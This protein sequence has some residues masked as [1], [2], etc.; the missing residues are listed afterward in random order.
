MC[1]HL[2]QVSEMK[3]N[4][5][6]ASPGLGDTAASPFVFKNY[7][8]TVKLNS[9]VVS[10]GASVV[11]YLV[12]FDLSLDPGRTNGVY[13]VTMDIQGT[14]PDGAPVQ[15]TFTSYVTI[16]DGKKPISTQEPVVEKPTSEPKLIISAYSVNPSPV[17][18]GKEFTAT[19]SFKNT[20]STKA[21]QNATVTVACESTNISLQNAS[22]TFFIKNLG[23]GKTTDINFK[24]KTDLDTPA[25]PIKITFAMSYDNAQA[26]AL[27]ST[28][29]ISV[30]VKQP[31]RVQMKVPQIEENV[32]AGDTLPL[33]FQVM[34][35][36]RSKIYNVRFELNAPGLIP[37]GAAFAGNMDA[38]T[39]SR[40]EMDLFI[41][42]K[43]MSKD[44][45]GKDKYG[46]STGMFTLIYED[47]TGKEYK[48]TEEF[49]TIIK[50]PVISNST[51]TPEKEVK[52]AGQWWVSIVI[53][54][55]VIAGLWVVLIV[56]RKK[57]KY[58]EDI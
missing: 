15:Q 33:S 53:G 32:S 57:E 50:E 31:L 4:I 55:I 45:K 56:R 27:T 37:T 43:D 49:S 13:P 40:A 7:Q 21:I 48:Q 14:G 12:R 30:D 23:K 35:M 44:Y 10:G 41:G 51:A 29:T 25:K 19:V 52:K 47:E 11:T 38:G 9:N 26:T 54:V 20:S 2:L 5:I 22:D 17:T 28:G 6:T 39:S 24:Y 8:K 18:A 3:N 36:G 46:T 42:T 34:N 58:N 1:F 16:T